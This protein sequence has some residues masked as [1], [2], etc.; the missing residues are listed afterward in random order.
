MGLRV[1]DCVNLDFFKR[2]C[3]K[4]FL[5]FPFEA[6]GMVMILHDVHTESLPGI[7]CTSCHKS[8]ALIVAMAPSHLWNLSCN[9]LV[10]SFSFLIL[11][12][13]SSSDFLSF[14]LLTI[15]AFDSKDEKGISIFG[16]S[17]LPK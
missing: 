9:I 2:K 17:L 8:W 11:V 12:L 4:E 1:W 14:L 5:D 15:S 13:L 10:L 6:A 3:W 16:T 7:M